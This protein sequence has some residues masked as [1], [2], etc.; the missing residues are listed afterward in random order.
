MFWL[1]VVLLSVVATCVAATTYVHDDSF[2]PDE[3]LRV[4]RA[5]TS[6]GGIYRYS[7]LV[8]GSI[9]GPPLKFL[10]NSTVWVRVYND[11]TDGNLTMVRQQVDGTSPQEG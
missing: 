9:P 6:I 2:T 10:E 11:M 4:T 5:N 1:R 3:V 7:T 8:N